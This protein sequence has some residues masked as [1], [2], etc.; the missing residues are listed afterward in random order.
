MKN[1]AARKTIIPVLLAVLIMFGGGAVFADS[2]VAPKP[3]EIWSEDGKKVFRWTPIPESN[4]AQ[5]GVYRNDELV[6]SV[7]NLP[8][9]GESASSFLFSEDF[10]YLVF[11]PSVS[12]VAALGFFEN[13]ILL[14]SYR[15]DELVRNMN[16]VTYSVTMASWENWSSRNFDTVSNTLTIVTL[17]DITYVFDI[18]TGEIIYDTVGDT[19]FIPHTEPFGFF[20]NEGTLPLWAEAPQEINLPPSQSP[21]TIISE[22]QSPD[23]TPSSTPPMSVWRRPLIWVLSL[24][25]VITALTLIL[26]ILVNK[27][28]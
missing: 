18:A 23:E 2:F 27:R 21:D 16:I 13:G 4:R 12:H 19:P 11:R 6:Y 28:R 15:I 5:A 14:R 8:I 17:D 1:L 26:R 25:L 7:E 22:N 9:M 10:R 20:A 24:A 3:F